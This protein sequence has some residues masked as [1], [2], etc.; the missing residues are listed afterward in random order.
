MEGHWYGESGFSNLNLLKKGI[1]P[2]GHALWF[3][4]LFN[5]EDD[6]YYDISPNANA[7]SIVPQGKLGS[8]LR[9]D[10]YVSCR[11]LSSIADHSPL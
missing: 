6:T 7:T 10:L 8:E 1:A 11:I 2:S 4:I 5:D 9:P 3:G